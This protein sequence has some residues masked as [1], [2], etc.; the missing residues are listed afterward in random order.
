MEKQTVLNESRLM[1]KASIQ[2]RSYRNRKRT[3][4]VAWGDNIRVDDQI[5]VSN[6][7]VSNQSFLEIMVGSSQWFSEARKIK[8]T[9]ME[10]GDE[11]EELMPAEDM[12]VNFSREELK[13][14]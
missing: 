13:K 11:V 4:F 9:S 1:D 12:A 3:K 5:G 10:W 8:L 2:T 7:K 14:T 6:N